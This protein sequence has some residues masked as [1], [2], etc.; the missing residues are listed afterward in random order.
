MLFSTSTFS[1]RASLSSSRRRLEGW[2]GSGRFPS[3]L[4]SFFLGITLCYLNVS[5]SF[6]PHN[7]EL[8][9]NQEAAAVVMTNSASLIYSKDELKKIFNEIVKKEVQ[10]NNWDMGCND[11]QFLAPYFRSILYRRGW[12]ENRSRK[13]IIDVGANSGDD[14]LSI[15]KSFQPIL[16]MCHPY[17]IPIQLI[18]VEPSP[19]VFCEM[20]DTV[21][22]KL[23][24]EDS[25]NSL[26]L[27][28]AL[29][30]KTGHLIFADPGNEGGKLIGDN[31][32]TLAKMTPGEF[33][34]FSH[35]KYEDGELTD[36][37]IDNDRKSAVPTYTLDLLLSSL[38]E[39]GLDKVH[40]DEEIFVV[41]IDTEGHDYNVLLGAKDL[42]RRK[43]ITFIIFEVWT[44]HFVKLIAQYMMQ[45][46]YQCFLLT[47]DTLVPVQERDW[48]YFH[49]DNF[50]SGWWGN[51]LCGIKGSNDMQLLWRMYHSDNL[52]LINSYD[53]L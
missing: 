40:R 35:C 4:L 1:R 6:I 8:H 12:S 23:V 25:R 20:T 39:P 52:K 42:L 11:L 2:V 13:V 50:T 51:G 49:M 31:Y 16:Q 26:L 47:K 46:D 19:K 3:N 17:S 24:E 53:L 43:R 41:K 7:E 45:Y 22:T 48:W 37:H 15:L 10:Y 28:V 27:N 18:S 38:E 21:S 30:D 5:P 14:T 29:S 9:Q 34:S 32:T 33:E 36:M 44:N